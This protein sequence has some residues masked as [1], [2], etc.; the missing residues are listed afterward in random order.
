MKRPVSMN[1]RVGCHSRGQS[2]V[3]LA[4]VLPLMGL[5]LVAVCD[6]AR[7]FYAS[8]GV[9]D[10]AR[11]GVQYG[12]QN[13]ATAVDYAGMQQAALDDGA[14]ITGL[15]AAASSF[16]QCDTT[17]MSSCDNPCTGT[18]NNFVRVTVT[19]TFR[20][21]LTYPGVPQP[22]PLKSTAVMEVP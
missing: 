8:V 19:A 2:A 9:A 22:A 3:E 15:T 21:I 5:L 16:C 7:L 12:A 6:F 20:T 1:R 13:R 11:A 18:V 10:A 4:L 14:G 17:T